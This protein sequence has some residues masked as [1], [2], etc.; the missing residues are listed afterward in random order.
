MTIHDTEAE[1]MTLTD[2]EQ[3]P[4]Y[5]VLGATGGIG[6]ALCRQL[7][8]RGARL[9]VAA[10]SAEKLRALADELVAHLF[11][12]DTTQ[13]ARVDAWACVLGEHGRLSGVAHCVGP[14]LLK[15]A[16]LTS[17]AEWDATLAVNLTLAFAV[18][19]AS[20]RAMKDSGGAIVL[21]SSA[22]AR[23]GLANHEAV[24]AAKTGIIG[25]VLS[26]AASYAS[27]GI[28]VNGV[29]P[30]L[31]RTALTAALIRPRLPCTPWA[32]SA[33]RP[34]S[35]RPSRGCSTRGRAGLPGRSSASTVGSLTSARRRCHEDSSRDDAHPG[36]T[37]PAAQR[38]GPGGGQLRPLLDAAE[39]AGRIQPRPRIR[40]PAG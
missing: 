29:A 32:A 3:S 11:L 27:R 18:V 5:L 6:S 38:P 22:A 33:S 23:A 9:L 19:R 34:T 15:P 21:V 17:D 7:V 25:L 20:A 24:A 36:N 14:L 12:V 35:P 31:V 13:S 16:H 37:R 4:S 2:F 40:R 8:A 28:R 1:R 39:P 30:G 26:A 10:R